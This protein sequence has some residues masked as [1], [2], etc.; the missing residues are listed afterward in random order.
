MTKNTSD[1]NDFGGTVGGPILKDKL[2]GFFSYETIRQP[3]VDRH[4]PGVVPDAAVHGHR[5]AWPAAPPNGS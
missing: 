3:T 2:F 5:G 4:R 1:F